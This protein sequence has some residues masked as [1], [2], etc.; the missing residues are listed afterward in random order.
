MMSTNSYDRTLHIN[1]GKLHM[2]T[3]KYIDNTSIPIISMETLYFTKKYL[4]F[5][6]ENDT[7]PKIDLTL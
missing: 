6:N 1:I 5:L 2:S 4:T 3:E 7:T